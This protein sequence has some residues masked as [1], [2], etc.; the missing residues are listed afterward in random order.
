[1]TA[2]YRADGTLRQIFSFDS[3][4]Y[5][6]T[7]NLASPRTVCGTFAS[8]AM[9]LEIRNVIEAAG[10]SRGLLRDQAASGLTLALVDAEL[11]VECMAIATSLAWTSRDDGDD[12]LLL[13]AHSAAYDIAA[14]LQR[15]RLMELQGRDGD[16]PWRR[17]AEG[18]GIPDEEAAFELVLHV[19]LIDLMDIDGTGLPDS[20]SHIIDTKLRETL[21]HIATG[22]KF[23]R[24]SLADC[25][26]KYVGHDRSDEKKGK[27]CPTCDAKGKV[28]ETFVGCNRKACT[29]H[30]VDAETFPLL[31]A[32]E[33]R[34]HCEGTF[35]K[36]DVGEPCMR[37]LKLMSRQDVCPE[38]KGKKYLTP[39]RLRFGELDGVPIN[40]WPKEAVDYALDDASDAILVVAGQAGGFD[41]C[42][43]DPS[44]EHT[45]VDEL[46]AIPDEA[47][48]MRASWSLRLTQMHGP[49]SEQEMY[50]VYVKEVQ[51]NIAKAL[52]IGR[53]MGFIR[54]NGTRDT[55]VHQKL[56][57]DAYDAIGREPPLTPTGKVKTDDDTIQ[58]S[59]DKRLILYQEYK[60]K[61]YTEVIADGLRYALAAEPGVLKDTGRTSW[62]RYMHQ[63]PRK[64]VFRECWKPRDGF[65]Y[66]SS[67]WT[68][69]E[70][71]ALAQ[72]LVIMFGS[73]AMADAINAGQDLHGYLG[74]RIWNL[75]PR[76]V[77]DKLDYEEF[78]RRLAAGDKA[79]KLIRQFAKI[80]N[81]GFPGGL[82]SLV[83]YARGYGIIITE[84]ESNRV[85]KAWME[86][87]FQMPEYLETFSMMDRE[88]G[89]FGFTYKQ[90]VSGRIRGRVHY[91]NGCNTGFQGL[92]ADAMKVAMWW[93]I[94]EMYT[95]M[96]GGFK[97]MRE[98]YPHSPGEPQSPRLVHFKVPRKAD[99]LKS[100]TI[101]SPL[102]G[103]RAWLWI[104]DEGLL[105]V[106]E[107][108]APAAAARLSELMVAALSY[109]TPDVKTAADP[110]L[111]R[112][113]YKDAEGVYVEGVLVPWE[114]ES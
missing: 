106:P 64:G 8:N 47:H 82:R 44:G 30:K 99:A 42:D 57:A 43:Y 84:E 76:N 40:E 71:V 37:A 109:F 10:P 96:W 110:A 25:V 24:S 9:P 28:T 112:R 111:M 67:D 34:E 77:G 87:W 22:N 46:G 89:G 48:Q 38:C 52:D 4:S 39:W 16:I 68:A 56:V 103:S 90:W 26:K 51:S 41:T 59:G 92:V 79:I 102:Y 45:I 83:D 1:M 100:T 15:A 74:T 11:Y 6:I 7:P 60:T 66:L 33:A 36:D 18:F 3:E 49:R 58:Q 61:D 97:E 85:R 19:M 75:D 81:F 12:A 72:I 69:A 78:M 55:K 35:V 31:E 13:L 86:A 63:P 32:L 94:R 107:E 113:W 20:R 23:G 98:E 14:M 80:G 114:P 101:P 17:V 70:M 62:K 5:L 93:S 73:S 95:P 27:P 91:T 50:D 88:N 104:H 21:L 2:I 29:R 65:L 108:T 105:E 53:Q 54:E